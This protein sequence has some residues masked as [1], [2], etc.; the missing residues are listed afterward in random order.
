MTST[1]FSNLVKMNVKM[2]NLGPKGCGKALA[3]ASWNRK[4]AV[5]KFMKEEKP[6][7]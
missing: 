1:F 5:M 3:L 6:D 2:D 7:D 4:P